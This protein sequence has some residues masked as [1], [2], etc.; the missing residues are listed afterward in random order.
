MALFGGIV[1]MKVIGWGIDGC[2]FL[3]PFS[4]LVEKSWMRHISRQTQTD[5]YYD[6]TAIRQET[7]CLEIPYKSFG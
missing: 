4:Q 3:A 1:K 6:E 5:V 2:T 7:R